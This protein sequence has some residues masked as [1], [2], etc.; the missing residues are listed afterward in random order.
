MRNIGN[1]S[2][3]SFSSCCAV[4]RL[5]CAAILVQGFGLEGLAV[6]HLADGS[7]IESV[8]CL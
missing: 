1:G 4:M 6:G 2:E 5:L 3:G 8:R 7:H